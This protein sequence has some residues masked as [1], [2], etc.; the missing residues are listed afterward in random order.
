MNDANSI[1]ETLFN[2][3]I[4]DGAV[5]GMIGVV[6]L[7]SL[8]IAT[9][10]YLFTLG[11]NY[12]KSAVSSLKDQ[13]TSF[14][15]YEELA[16]T[17]L[18][19]GIIII[20]LPLINATTSTINY[21]NRFTAPGRNEY[22]VMQVYAEQYLE[23]GQTFAAT[24][25]LEALKK[26]LEEDAKL[27]A[28]E[29]M[30]ESERMKIEQMIEKKEQEKA[31]KGVETD[32]GEEEGEGTLITILKRSIKFIMTPSEWVDTIFYG[33]ALVL[34]GLIKMIIYGVAINVLKV[35]AIIG[36]LA[37][38]FSILPAFRNQMNIWAGTYLN[39]AFVFTTM[40]V[41]DAMLIASTK[42]FVMEGKS[43]DLGS[44][45]TSVGNMDSL[46]FLVTTIVMYLSVFW[47]TSKF[48]GK[49][50]G[51]MA[52]TKMVGIAAAAAGLMMVGGAAAGGGAASKSNIST[53]A[54]TATDMFKNDE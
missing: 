26:L 52:L 13:S 23:T 34:V 10:L 21:L 33:L 49:S 51:G 15:D 6:V 22:K 24:Y 5:N 7:I 12:L 37:F 31:E 44:Y 18:I 32:K 20:Y 48:I 36:P 46:F 25:S 42:L 8:V 28:G 9:M 16:R 30:S 35:L 47:L 14:V 45:G 54:N 29:R 17:L 1:L 19:I 2:S 40:N 43:T 3:N 27:P 41:I 38:A 11:F 53:A 39:V 50:D 4:I